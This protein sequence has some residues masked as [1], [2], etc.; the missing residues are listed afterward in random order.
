VFHSAAEN[1]EFTGLS[2]EPLPRHS[3]T[4]KFDLLL[5]AREE[6]DGSLACSVEYA[7]A[8]FDEDTVRALAARY[9]ALAGALVRAPREP[10]W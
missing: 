7:A 8:L 4:S 3:R 10:L 5:A 6:Q 9:T 2:A 1:W